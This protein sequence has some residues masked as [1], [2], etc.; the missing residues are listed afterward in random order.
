MKVEYKTKGTCSTKINLVV[1]DEKI[2]SVEFEDG[3]PGNLLAIAVLV[4]GMKVTEAIERLEGIRCGN[5]KTSCA[6]QLAK[7]LKTT[8]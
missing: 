6:D 4:K 5:K 1:E 2:E 3:C 8:L 7:A